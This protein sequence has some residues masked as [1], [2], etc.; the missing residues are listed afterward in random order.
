MSIIKIDMIQ[1]TNF[2]LNRLYKNP[3]NRITEFLLIPD[4]KR[5]EVFLLLRRH[6]QFEIAKGLD[7]ANIKLLLESLDPDD[8]TDV[9]Q[10]FD[11]RKQKEIIDSLAEDNQQRLSLLL[12]FDE[13]T[14]GGLMGLNYIQL[15]S[16]STVSEVSKKF[17][18][19]EKRTGKPPEI[20]IMEDSKLIGYLPGFQLG[21]AKPGE[22]VKKYIKKA[23]TIDY[24]ASYDE[25]IEKFRSH[26]HN[27]V[28]VLDEHGDVLG[29]IYS[30]DV[31]K[32]L[33]EEEGASLYDFA[34][35]RDE[36]EAGD[37]P[38]K[39]INFRYKWLVINLATAFFASFIVG[40]F[41]DTI[42]RNI[43][44]AVYMPIVAGMG[45]NAATQTLAVMVRGISNRQ[46][47]FTNFTKP[48]LSEVISG[49]VNGV[50]N[51]ILVFAVV[52]MFNHDLKVAIVLA[53][54]M[55]I[56]LVVAAF[57][58]TIVPLI[59]KALKKDPASSATIFITTA[60]DVLGFLAFLG[61][62]SLIL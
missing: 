51:G 18:S 39:K 4:T 16:T 32:I 25:V 5:T 40:L 27:K 61:M 48:L 33:Q 38:L 47:D 20:L 15:L 9:L 58:G 21:F 8:A 52:M 3:K 13:N 60:T 17:R 43:L 12:K 37:P 46:I 44:L 6:I 22:R 41:D 28:V 31:L 10:F 59:M 34:G 2:Y 35:V 56:N 7:Q 62:A 26:P 19:H 30:D 57:F 14:A 54:A 53:F 45:G 11:S 36:E 55:V 1:K 42:N 49:F 24:R 29:I 23:R 50:I